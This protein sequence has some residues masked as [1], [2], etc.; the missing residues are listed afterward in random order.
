[1]NIDL[2]RFVTNYLSV[3]FATLMVVSF[4][5]FVSIP[6]YLGGDPGEMRVPERLAQ[7]EVQTPAPAGTQVSAPLPDA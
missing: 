7:T 2:Q 1:M 3:V 6:F 4:F 5:S